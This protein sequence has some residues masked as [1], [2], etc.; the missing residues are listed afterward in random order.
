M[1]LVEEWNIEL[2]KQRE[3][4]VVMVKMNEPSFSLTVDAHHSMTKCDAVC[5]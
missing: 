3:A 5:S 4:G 1:F 2:T